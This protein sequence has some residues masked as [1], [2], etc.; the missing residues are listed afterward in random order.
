MSLSGMR[1]M[2]FRGST[3]GFTEASCERCRN[4]VL[5]RKSAKKGAQVFCYE[6]TAIRELSLGIDELGLGGRVL[7]EQDL[8][9][10]R[11]I[12]QERQR[13]AGEERRG[14]LRA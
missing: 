1:C 10:L 6:C 9:L 2:N 3:K 5:L 14:G 12:L 7:R 13:Q 4:P 11:E 8:K